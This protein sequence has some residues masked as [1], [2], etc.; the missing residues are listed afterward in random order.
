MFIKYYNIYIYIY[1]LKLKFLYHLYSG[2][3]SSIHLQEYIFVIHLQ[4]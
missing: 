4:V 3:F 2:I 1:I